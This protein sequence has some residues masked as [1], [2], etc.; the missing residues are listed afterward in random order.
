MEFITDDFLLQGAG[1][2][3]LYHGYAENAPILDY[4]C[5]IAAEAIAENASFGNL[6]NVWLDDDHY[7]WTAM[8]CCGVEER[9]I[10]GD[11][12]DYEKFL[13]YARCLES[14]VGNP[15]YH[16]SHLELKK[17]FGFTGV[18]NEMT[19]PQVWALANERLSR[20]KA[21]DFM[22]EADVRLI[23]TTDDPA[24]DLR[25]HEALANEG[26]SIRVLPAFRPDKALDLAHP[27]L[28]G[29]IAR[30]ES[31]CGNPIRDL[32]SLRA[33]LSAR[34]DFF[35]AHGCRLSDHA[36][37]A[38]GFAEGADAEADAALQKRLRGEPVSAREALLYQTRMLLWLGEQYHARSWAM[39]LHFGVLRDVN[40]TLMKTIGVDAGGD[41]IG[42]PSDIQGL[43]R[44]MAALE[45]EGRLPRMILYSINPTDN[46]SLSVLAGCFQTGEARGKIQH[47]SAW[48]FNDTKPGMESHLR[49]L[50][51]VGA[52][53]SFV[54]MLTDSRSFLSY[55]R[56]DY[57]RRILCNYLGGLV[58][59]GEYPADWDALGKLVGNICYQNAVD[60]FQF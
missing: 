30:L 41:C 6:T 5:H 45:E 1:A 59:A 26:F 13:A 27:A 50:A 24:D 14:C 46:A 10:T 51:S 18:L 58:D 29:Y 23:C 15:L 8:R 36:L 4:H 56:H 12:D 33:A 32:A 39:Q 11:A 22:Y 3:R 60:Y 19:A 47:G 17:Y 38:V 20:M 44:L 7:K 42:A 2:R 40:P 9:L 49:T 55:T 37:T 16:W 21:R 31:V 35:A 48:W 57:F 43:A 54:G 25:Y 34:M 52:L 28:P 53:G